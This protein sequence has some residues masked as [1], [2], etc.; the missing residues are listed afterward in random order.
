MPDLKL[1]CGAQE[2]GYETQDV[3]VAIALVL[4]Q[5]HR[6][7]AHAQVGPGGG[8]GGVAQETRHAAGK[9]SKKPDRPNLDMEWGI[10]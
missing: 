9:S 10:F 3:N 8:G 2:Y 5:Y 6:Q 4:L 7:D 1:K